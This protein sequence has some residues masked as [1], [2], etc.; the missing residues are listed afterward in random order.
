M[1]FFTNNSTTPSA[2]ITAGGN[3]LIGT[4]TD[5]GARLQVNGSVTA[6]NAIFYKGVAGPPATSGTTQTNSII[7]LRSTSNAVLDIGMNTGD[8]G[9]WLQVGDSTDLSPTYAYPLCLQ[10]NGGRVGIGTA[11][12]SGKLSVNDSVYGEYLRVATGVIGGNQTSVFLAWNN[13]GNITLQQVVV[14]AADSGGTGF[15][16]LRIPNT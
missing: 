2:T 15:R 14:G 11:S 10:P 6:A 7:R 3:V 12:P 9:S 13:G 4:T 8:L 16:L 5:N 1:N